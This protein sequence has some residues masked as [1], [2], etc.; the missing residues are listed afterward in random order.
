ML[1]RAVARL[2]LFERPEDYDALLR[3]LDETWEL[4][5]LPILAMVVMPNQWH[6]VVR[7]RKAGQVREFF[8]RL[9]LTHCMRWHAHYQTGGTGPFYQGRF[10]SFPV[11]DDQA[12]AHGNAL[13]RAESIAR[14]AGRRRGK[15]A[16]EFGVGSTPDRR[17]PTTLAHRAGRSALAANLADMGQSAAKRSRDRGVT[18]LHSPGFSLRRFEV[19]AAERNAAQPAIHAPPPVDVPEKRPDP[20]CSSTIC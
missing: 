8:R 18:H 2:T 14:R 13:F 3:V 7:P 6:F 9:S 11:Q 4:T 10:K 17:L 12:F 5:P 15:L 20:F 16:L 19:E 1:N